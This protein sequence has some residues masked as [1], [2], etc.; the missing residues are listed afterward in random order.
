MP[1]PPPNDAPSVGAV[2]GEGGGA[3]GAHAARLGA[4]GRGSSSTA[5]R[6]CQCCDGVRP[7]SIPPQYDGAASSFASPGH[8]AFV[9][10]NNSAAV[11]GVRTGEPS[12]VDHSEGCNSSAKAAPQLTDGE[13]TVMIPPPADGENY[14]KKELIAYALRYGKPRVLNAIPPVTAREILYPRPRRR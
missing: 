9:S 6:H 12:V 14:T 2:G 1:P 5:S 11:V 10:I 4:V 7:Q 3:L 8:S 13:G